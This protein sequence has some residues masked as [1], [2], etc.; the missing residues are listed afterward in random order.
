MA[1]PILKLGRLLIATLQAELTDKELMEFQSEITRLVGVHRAK[2]VVIDVTALDV[3]D[4]F[5]TKSLRNIAE[6]VKLR[7]AN[8]VVVGIHPDVAFTM[9]QL[10]LTLYGIQTAIDLE[11][12]LAV[13]NASTHD[14]TPNG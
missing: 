12:G 13:L 5:A 2:G 10:G 4:S 1:I 8:A 9:V 6:M 7:G 11:H 14:I 3:L